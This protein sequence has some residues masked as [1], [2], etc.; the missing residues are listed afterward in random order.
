M[1]SYANKSQES[2]ETNTPSNTKTSRK[3][4]EKKTFSANQHFLHPNEMLKL[5]SAILYV[6]PKGI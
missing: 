5:V 4:E 2:N 6:R 1:N 3:N